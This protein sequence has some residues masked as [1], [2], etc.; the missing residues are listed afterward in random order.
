MVLT[1]YLVALRGSLGRISI[2]KL[3]LEL[4]QKRDS[5]RL[6]RIW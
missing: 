5:R 4:L 6:L 1:R 2:G 3:E